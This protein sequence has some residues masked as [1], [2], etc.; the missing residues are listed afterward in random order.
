MTKKMCKLKYEISLTSIELIF[1]D[2][3]SKNLSVYEIR[4]YCDEN[5][6]VEVGQREKRLGSKREEK[7][8][9]VKQGRGKRVNY[10]NTLDN[11]VG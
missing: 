4:S 8:E 3:C 11:S 5:M 10:S 9:S 7:Q 6:R 2:D 1:L